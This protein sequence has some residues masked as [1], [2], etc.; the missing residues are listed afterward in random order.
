MVSSQFSW[1]LHFGSW[2]DD[3]PPQRLWVDVFQKKRLYVFR[4][5]YPLRPPRLQIQSQ[6]SVFVETPSM[7]GAIADWPVPQWSV[8]SITSKTQPYHHQIPIYGILWSDHRFPISVIGFLISVYRQFGTISVHRTGD[9]SPVVSAIFRGPVLGMQ[10]RVFL[11]L[12]F[13]NLLP[14]QHD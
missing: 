3:M 1:W 6:G 2:S 9:S 13:T 8:Q 7:C 5:L 4:L 14:H 12:V 11:F 10:S